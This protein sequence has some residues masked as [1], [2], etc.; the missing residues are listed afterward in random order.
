MS[1]RRARTPAGALAVLAAALALQPAGAEAAGGTYA[2]VQCDPINRNVSGLSIQD[3]PSYAVKQRCADPASDHAIKIANTRFARYG[4]QGEIR[5]STGSPALRIVGVDVQARLRRHHGHVPRL[6]VADREGH[7]LTQVAAG[8]NKRT[9]FKRYSWRSSRLLPQQFVARLRCEDHKGCPRS[10]L[11]KAWLRNVHFM[12]GDY[13]D[14]GLRQPAGT[15]FGQGWNRGTRTVY[16]RASD[17]GSGVRRLAITVNGSVI[18]AGSGNCRGTLQM[19]QSEGFQPCESQH[20]LATQLPTAVP[21]FHDGRNQISACALDFARNRS[22]HRRT[23]HVDNTKPFLAFTNAQVPDDPELIRAV[24]FDAT[25]GVSGGRI[26]YRPKGAESWRPLETRLRNGELRT[27][28][29]STQD[30]PGRYEFMAVASDA[31]GNTTRSTQHGDGRPMVLTFPLKSGV[32]LS[33]HLTGGAP[34]L[35]V[36][37]GRSSR[38]SG[39]LTDAGGLPLANQEVTVT[40]SFGDGALIDRRIRTVT[41]DADGRWQERLP[42][43][44]SRKVTASYAGTRRYLADTAGV[45][46]LRVRTKATLRLSRRKVAEGHRVAFKGRVGHLAARIPAGGKLVELEVKDGRSWQTVEHPFYTRPNGRYRLRYRFARFYT[47]NVHYRF[48]VRVL[49]EREWPYKAP[50][51]SHVRK[52]VVKAR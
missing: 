40:E 23:V 24:A 13:A 16:I 41:T 27:R 31:A 33:G 10:E 44:P 38:V 48:R 25:S 47:S 37:Y 3:A 45:G 36:N 18:A 39:V 32:R 28:V 26:Y 11:A 51:R 29:D 15:L 42:P 50:A 30:P 17:V 20:E 49:R 9:G 19:S 43:G 22:C 21:P 2:V 8:P 52:L 6:L 34:R 12:V 1:L 46:S 7:E 5:W 14:P 4:R 35:T